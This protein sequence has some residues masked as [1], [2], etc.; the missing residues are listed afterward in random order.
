MHEGKTAEKVLFITCRGIR[1]FSHAC[2]HMRDIHVVNIQTP[3]VS[4]IV[5]D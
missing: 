2:I 1:N 3:Q 4:T 5:H